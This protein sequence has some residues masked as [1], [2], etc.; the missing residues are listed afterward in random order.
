M[1]RKKIIDE[2]TLLETA[3]SVFLEHGNAGTTK[4]VAKRAGI[5]EAA[6]FSRYPTKTALF[7]AALM[8]THVD[9]N[10][11]IAAEIEDPRDALVETGHRLLRHFRSVIPM[12]LRLMEN[13]A[14]TMDDLG[15]NFGHERVG[16]VAHQLAEF[17]SRKEAEGLIKVANPLAAAHL[18]IA[19]IHSLPLYEM[20]KFHGSDNLDHSIEFFV[21]ALCAGLPP[22]KGRPDD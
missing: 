20:M 13:S 17:L 1:G 7:V 16:N 14:V 12:A 15:R 18:F 21:D 5:S 6:I 9:M 2:Q 22:V 10:G 3:R 19:A 4:E 8:S 11:L